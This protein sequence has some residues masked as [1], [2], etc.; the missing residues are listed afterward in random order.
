[1]APAATPTRWHARLVARRA[2][3]GLV[4]VTLVAVGFGAVH[5]QVR[6]G[7]DFP[8][9]WQAARELLAGRSPYD[10][11]SGLHGY[12]YLP[13]FALL[14]S[15]LARLP[16]PAAAACWY[17]ANVAFVTL[18]VR[19]LLDALRAA[20][21][22]PRVGLLLLATLPLAGL[23]HDNL[24][25]GQ[26]NILLLL[27]VAA[28]VQGALAPRPHALHGMALGFAAA[29]KMPAGLLLLPLAIRGRGRALAGFAAGATLALA[30][31]LLLTGPASGR[32]MLQSWHAKVVAPATAGTLQGSSIIDQSPHAGLRR[33]LVA[34][35]AYTGRSVNLRAL[36]PEAIALV[37]RGVASLLLAAYLFVWLVAP[38][39]NTPRALLLDLA[40]GC[41]AMVQV[42]G[43]SLKAQFVV[44]L[45]PAWLAATLASSHPA[46][47]PRALL[48]AAGAL[49]LLSQ[50][51][52]VGRAASNE[53]LAWSSMTVGTLLLAGALVLL[54]FALATPSPNA[55][56]A[57]V[58]PAG[59]AR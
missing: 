15:P 48:A 27:L 8:I 58:P 50:P 7:N 19:A 13:W 1:M 42:T 18:V 47:A 14:L 35:P 37:S 44:L 53:L 32:Q 4:L 45:L 26:A 6:D 39:R 3:L 51:G 9:Y 12:V 41:C 29:L 54:R 33:L 57:A 28:T 17:V 56:P 34:E 52:L 59:T 40:L 22:T 16:L 21:A 43:F 5:K 25:L 55:S 20:G 23:V 11:G 38:A 31:P 46:R 2:A 24:V 49:F 36:S 30:L 10:V